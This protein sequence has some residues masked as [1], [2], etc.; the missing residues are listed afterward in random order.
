MLRKLSVGG[1]IVLQVG[2]KWYHLGLQYFRPRRPT[3]LELMKFPHRVWGCDVVKPKYQSNSDC[4]LKS[5]S[6]AM[7]DAP[8][9]MALFVSLFKLVPFDRS[10]PNW[11]PDRL[12]TIKPLHEFVPDLLTLN[13]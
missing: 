10:I 13:F 2:E 5:S 12:L 3:L 4:T 6:E 9:Q 8:L 1:W 7:L 11:T